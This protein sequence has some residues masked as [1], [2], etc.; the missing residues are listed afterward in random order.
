MS[1]SLD[2]GPL[3]YILHHA[4]FTH[5]AH[6]PSNAEICTRVVAQQHDNGTIPLIHRIRLIMERGT[7]Q[8]LT[9]CFISFQTSGFIRRTVRG[10]RLVEM[11]PVTGQSR[12]VTRSAFL[13]MWVAV[14]TNYRTRRTDCLTL[15]CIASNTWCLNCSC[16]AK[17]HSLCVWAP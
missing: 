4:A 7:V 8:G 6:I 3:D 1:L 10:L 17:T 14:F 13:S 2:M 5:A 15:N 9:T 11:V 12:E 16:G